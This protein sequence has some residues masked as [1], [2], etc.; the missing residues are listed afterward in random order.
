MIMKFEVTAVIYGRKII[1]AESEEE[2][3][4]ASAVMGFDDFNWDD[5][6]FADIKEVGE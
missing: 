3:I 1:E 4:D 5:L 6:I 2:I